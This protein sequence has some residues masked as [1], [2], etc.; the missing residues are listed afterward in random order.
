MPRLLRAIICIVVLSVSGKALA[1]DPART[2]NQ[3]K[4]TAWTVDD[5]APGR[6]QA[7]VQTKDGFLLLGTATGLYRFDGFSF[8]KIPSFQG[9]PARSDSVWALMVARNGDVW[10]GHL[11]GGVSIYRNGRLEDAKDTALVGRVRAI[12]Q[13][14][15]GVVWVA[16][17]GKDFASVQRFAGGKWESINAA[18]G[19]PK[20]H[21]N[22]IV[23]T[24]NGDL[25][26][27]LPHRLMYLPRGG[28]HLQLIK[29]VPISDAVI[30][31]S[32][33]GRIWLFDTLGIRELPARLETEILSNSPPDATGGVALHKL[34]FDRDGALWGVDMLNGVEHV[35]TP[36]S[37]P[38]GE[39][40]A[41][42][43]TENF[44]QT[45]GLTSERAF[46]IFED[47][48]GNIWAGT[49]RGLDR[50]RT[51]PI[52]K[53]LT[54]SAIPINA[55]ASITSSRSGTIYGITYDK[56]GGQIFEVAPKRPITFVGSFA[57]PASA[58]CPARDGGVWFTSGSPTAL[59]HVEDSRISRIPFPPEAAS[60]DGAQCAE[61]GYGHVWISFYRSGI[62]YNLFRYGGGRW[63]NFNRDPRLAVMTPW[64]MQTDSHGRLL[65]YYSQTFLARIDNN[66]TKP[67]WYQ[68][69]IAISFIHV[70]YSGAR[71]ILLGGESGLARYD[72]KKFQTLSSTRFP[73]LAHVNGIAQTARG[74]T[75]LVGAAGIVRLSTQ[76]LEAAFEHPELGLNPRIFN[77]HDGLV[78]VTEDSRYNHIAI[79]ADG[80]LWFITADGFFWINPRTLYPNRLAP[81][82]KIRSLSAG[83]VIYPA[84]GKVE[85]PK[86]TSDVNI[87][88]AAVSLSLPQRIHY[89]YRLDGIDADWVDP[90]SRRDAIYTNLG[91]GTYRFHVIASNNDG[92]WNMEGATLLFV[93]PPT[94]LQSNLFVVL[95]MLAGSVFLWLL[96]SLRLRQVTASIRT[97]M[98]DRLAE[99]ERIAR[100]LHDTLLQGIDGLILRFQSI[101]NRM[102]SDDPLRSVM[103]ETLERA[104]DVLS[105]SRD[106]MR[107]L[108]HAHSGLD[109]SDAFAAAGESGAFR[110]TAK[111]RIV[112]EGMPRKLHPIVRDEV[113]RIGNE[114]IS[115]AFRH[116][117]AA[118]I[119]VATIYFRNRLVVTVTDD[120]AGIPPDLLEHGRVGHFGLTG[121]RERAGRI[122]AELSVA[123]RVGAGTTMTLTV[124]ASVAYADA[125]GLRSLFWW[126]GPFLLN[127]HS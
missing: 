94:F 98:Q 51:A 68:K 112:R 72:G 105:E 6:I 3:F 93:I 1:L 76:E 31:E 123:S 90:G 57:P 99:R 61:D 25:W 58:L 36:R 87:S 109:I 13:D 44:H 81:P 54:L 26:F 111:F 78:G 43:A 120:G 35:R 85:L 5:G 56:N 28:H 12:V 104:D 7:I 103:D 45:D 92:V 37:S 9:K 63:E 27:C 29:N 67:I 95:C 17:D 33:D 49:I 66:A 122:G 55:S 23:A 113:I 53:E 47:R 38:G 22:D 97:R 91:A 125:L 30:T 2:I 121:M 79:G 75:W 32:R 83:N 88:Y 15:A 110:S 102:Q 108:R 106:S 126:P 65:V 116:A 46:S 82:V 11:W 62:G 52:V 114:A 59:V 115:N 41:D 84:S 73:F 24:R 124:S 96:Y 42:G 14:A 117:R 119:E 18:W 16:A 39:Q 80:R 100:D 19:V 71:Y 77:S 118:N 50:F 89:R 107:N 21:L 10:V 74:E 40:L 69:D 101:A 4:H 127:R 64:P 60:F 34:I 48:E 20:E 70:I 86:G 8:E